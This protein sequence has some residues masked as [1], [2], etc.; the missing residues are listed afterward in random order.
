MQL[1]Q[2]NVVATVPNEACSA[3]TNPG[4]INGNIALIDRGNCAFVNK[5]INA[6]NAG[7]IGVII[8][9]N[10]Q[11]DGVFNMGG[12]SAGITIPSAMLSFE[13]CQTLRVEIGN[14]LNA[15]LDAF[16]TVPNTDSDLDNGIIA[17]EFGHGISN[18]LTGGAGNTGCLNGDEQMGEGWSDYYSLLLQMKPGDMADDRNGI[19]TYVTFDTPDGDGIRPFPYSRDLS[20]N[21]FS[22]NDI[23]S[24]VSI[25]HGV[26]SV[27]CTVLWDMTWELIDKHGFSADPYDLN[28]G[29]GISMQLVMEG[30]KLQPCNVGFV[31]GRDAILQADTLL[32]GGDNSCEIW[33]A[34]ARRGLGVGANEGS[35]F[36]V[37][38]GVESFD[39][40]NGC[41]DEMIQPCTEETLT[42]LNEEILDGTNERVNTT[43]TIDNSDV[44]AGSEVQLRAGDDID[45]EQMEVEDNG[46]L[47][48]KVIPCDDSVLPK[49]KKL[50][51]MRKHKSPYQDASKN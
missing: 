25:P 37:T 35:V 29:N 38:D 11:G 27:W 34:F 13:D 6:Q 1:S 7:A 2:G 22:Y 10:I 48:L 23:G 14:G 18:R 36:S 50:E 26:G 43:I 31:S 24:G 5:V 17:H 16:R 51:V 32:F 47:F 19:G 12:S 9:N 28:S 4:A 45:I 39:R 20:I 30:M 42:F 44:L 46:D 3:V 21:P 33:R 49:T 40:P 8:C 15:T 41:F